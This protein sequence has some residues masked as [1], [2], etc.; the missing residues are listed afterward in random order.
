MTTED[1]SK[2]KE[3]KHPR[4]IAIIGGGITGLATS[5]YAAKRYPTAEIVLY[6]ASNRL[7]RR[8]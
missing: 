5:F 6:E 1:R 8:N 4:R 7:G 2:C 3:E